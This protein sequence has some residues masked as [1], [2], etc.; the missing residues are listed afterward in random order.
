MPMDVIPRPL[1]CRSPEVNRDLTSV[2]LQFISATS[3]TVGGAFGWIPAQ[4]LDVIYE[5]TRLMATL[6]NEQETVSEWPTG[7]P[8]P[9][10]I[11][12]MES[13]FLLYS[14]LNVSIEV[15]KAFQRSVEN[16]ELNNWTQ[17]G[18]D[19][20]TEDYLQNTLVTHDRIKT[21]LAFLT[22]LGVNNHE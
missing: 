2:L 11:I 8:E 3:A 17:I 7:Q 1:V 6:M 4:V 19:F 15:T 14:A 16:G 22:E 21:Y 10:L 18:D 20:A 9:F 5:A 12:D 13:A